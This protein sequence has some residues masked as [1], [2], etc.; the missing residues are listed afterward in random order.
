[1]L[2]QLNGVSLCSKTALF[3]ALDCTTCLQPQCIFGTITTIWTYLHWSSCHVIPG[4]KSEH[5]NLSE[6][7][8]A[9]VILAKMLKSIIITSSIQLQRYRLASYLKS[10]EGWN[11]SFFDT[12]REIKADIIKIFLRNLWRILIGRSHKNI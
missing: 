6:D 3:L 7:R 10:V 5:E 9:I 12:F 11:C 8:S 2:E 4:E 1:M